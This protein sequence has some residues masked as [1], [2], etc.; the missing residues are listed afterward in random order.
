MRLQSFTAASLLLSACIAAEG[1]GDTASSPPTGPESLNLPP[2]FCEG[3]G[4]LV[5]VPGSPAPGSCTAAFDNAICSCTDVRAAGYVRVASR[6]LFEP[7]G[8]LAANS[9]IEVD[10]FAHVG[11][12]VIA[13]GPESLGFFG[14]LHTGG[15]L[16]AGGNVSTHELD[17]I[18]GAV[19]VGGDARVAGDFLLLGAASIAGDLRQPAG[20]AR[21]IV[22]A[23]GGDIVDGPVT[24]EPPCP[25][26]P[27]EIIDIETPIA[28]ALLAND[29][30]LLVPPLRPDEL[31]NVVGVATRTLPCGVYYLD[32]ISGT[33]VI[34]V[35][36]AGRVV[37]LVGGDV[38][39]IGVL[40][41]SFA[42]DA[43]LDLFIGGDLLS[44]GADAIGNP[45][46]PG[47]TRTYVAGS[48]DIRLTGASVFAG[49]VYA[50]RAHIH[51]TGATAVQGSLFGRSIHIP[52]ALDVTYDPSVVGDQCEEEPIID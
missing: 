31:T 19:D 46:R 51:G 8:N 49:N 15:N 30:D 6:D 18:A 4:P 47:S 39:T 35:H 36:I 33:G 41:L 20:K 13:A 43:E 50:P 52:G 2:N 34:S 16:V 27:D 22:M 38:D 26:E 14:A 17:F 11:G 32:E 42:P 10:G 40:H 12:D 29:N 21:P 1:G 9:R 5:Q 45:L 44:I 48:G 3:S 7:A 24:V 23:V 37:L 28:E 25:C